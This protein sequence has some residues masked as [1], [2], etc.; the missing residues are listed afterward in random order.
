MLFDKSRFKYFNKPTLSYFVRLFAKLG[1]FGLLLTG[2][3][4]GCEKNNCEIVSPT[5]E[6][7]SFGVVDSVGALLTL[8]F[9]DCDGDVGLTDA[10][11]FGQFHVD[12][13]FH[14][15]LFLEYYEME[16]GVWFKWDDLG[17]PL[18]PPFYY[19]IPDLRS[20]NPKKK[21][22]GDIQVKLEPFYYIPFSPRDTFKFTIRFV[23]R[24][25]NWSNEVETPMMVKP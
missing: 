18:D 13:T 15:N 16:N 8:G 11:T 5:L 10:D 20:D 1:I 22:E 6:F 17:P 14:H 21:L 7:K 23:D 9:T 3:I 2:L 12:S 24:A 25:L 4:F 19:R